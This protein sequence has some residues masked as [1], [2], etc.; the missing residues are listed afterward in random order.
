[1]C[2]KLAR[3][4]KA[5]AWDSVLGVDRYVIHHGGTATMPNLH[6]INHPNIP[7]KELI[8]AI[9]AIPAVR[10]LHLYLVDKGGLRQFEGRSWRGFHHHIT[11]CFMAHY[12]FRR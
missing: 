2:A 1:M 9:E 10:A 5:T 11:L 3:E 6:L 7:R 8:T 12:F 4:V